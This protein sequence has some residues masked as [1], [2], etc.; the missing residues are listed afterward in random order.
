MVH[1]DKLKPYLCSPPEEWK[2]FLLQAP[3]K[4]KELEDIPVEDVED[5]PETPEHEEHVQ[6]E[7][8]GQD[9]S[10]IPGHE[11][12]SVVGTPGEGAESRNEETFGRP[13]RRRR[14]P[15]WLQ[16]YEQEFD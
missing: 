4:P 7:S 13:A 14:P 9:E 8:E 12:F 11:T 5:A 1:Y 16:D 6:A 10:A 15:Q 3:E 2:D